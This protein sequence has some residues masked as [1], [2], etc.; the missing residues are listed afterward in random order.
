MGDGT[1]KAPKG[2]RTGSHK[3][4][5]DAVSDVRTPNTALWVVGLRVLAAVNCGSASAKMQEAGWEVAVNGETDPSRCWIYESA[6]NDPALP[7]KLAA[8]SGASL[9]G[10]PALTARRWTASGL[11]DGDF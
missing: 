5:A 10:F 2:R 6:L 4:L 7:A 8:F 1:V 11:T 9:V 3:R